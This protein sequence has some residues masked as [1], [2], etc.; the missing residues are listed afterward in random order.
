MLVALQLHETVV[1]AG[2]DGGVGLADVDR[3]DVQSLNQ[4]QLVLLVLA[5]VDRHELDA[6]VHRPQVVGIID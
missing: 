5:Q 3:V 2:L 6:E 4:G 1:E